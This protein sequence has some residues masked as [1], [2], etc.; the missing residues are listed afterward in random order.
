MPNSH[1]GGRGVNPAC[2]TERLTAYPGRSLRVLCK[3]INERATV[4]RKRKEVSRGRSRYCEQLKLF[5]RK[6]EPADGEAVGT[7]DAT[8]TGAELCSRLNQ[9]SGQVNRNRRST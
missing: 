5:T 6:G 3:G 2:Q 9:M 1:T 7:S 4:R 8:E